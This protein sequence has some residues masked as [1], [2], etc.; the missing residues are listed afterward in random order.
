[1][2]KRH[3]LPAISTMRPGWELPVET[4]TRDKQ[5][6][7]LQKE[8]EETRQGGPAIS[9]T[10]TLD[11]QL[12]K[13]IAIEVVRY[14]SLP[15]A[16]I[17]ELLEE[18]E[19]LH[20]RIIELPRP[21]EDGETTPVRTGRG[22]DLAS[23]AAPFDWVGPTDEQVAAYSTAYDKWLAE[24]RQLMETVPV[25]MQEAEF[26][27]VFDLALAN[28]GAAAAEDVWVSFEATAG[29][30]LRDQKDKDADAE[31][32]GRSAKA[33]KARPL[34]LRAPPT[35]P[36]W[37]KV[38]RK[39]DPPSLPNVVGLHHSSILSA[40]EIAVRLAT[41]HDIGG[42]LAAQEKMAKL[43]LPNMVGLH[44]SGIQSAAEIAVLLAT[45]HDIGGLLAAQERMPKLI[46]S[47][48]VD[49]FRGI[50]AVDHTNLFGGAGAFP[51]SR[52]WIHDVMPL[53]VP[54]M[55]RPRDPE[56]FY[57]KGRPSVSYS[58]SWQFECALLRHHIVPK[59][60]TVPV[61]VRLDALP[62]KGGSV[63]VKVHARNLRTPFEIAFPVRVA[64]RD[65]DTESLVR[66]LLPPGM[67]R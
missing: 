4:D 62:R 32:G 40:A 60:W 56:K 59:V 36:S 37:R 35:A 10:T 9:V 49:A 64:I 20:P 25:S 21:A 67:H 46:G 29:L 19:R 12:A 57:W 22:F 65:E 39:V 16:R 50:S 66:A 15:E 3:G 5:I 55:P 27:A 30:L 48:G 53:P 28:V 41:R 52:A 54:L 45:R 23:I 38:Y 42:L 31:D 26:E 8:L 11:G 14:P 2:A 58:E 6:H 13:E 44:H 7:R 24:A 17:S 33:A 43:N 51:G 34:A 18:L 1:M 61:V 63:E 47:P